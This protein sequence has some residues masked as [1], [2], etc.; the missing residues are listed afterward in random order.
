MSL[1][2]SGVYAFGSSSDFTEE[3]EDNTSALY[4]DDPDK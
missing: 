2:K 4:H 3:G 1:S